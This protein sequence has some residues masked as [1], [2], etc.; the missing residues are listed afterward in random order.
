VVD[1]WTADDGVCDME[2]SPDGKT[3]LVATITGIDIYDTVDWTKT[4][5]LY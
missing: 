5:L 1:K 3:L 4:R 2:F